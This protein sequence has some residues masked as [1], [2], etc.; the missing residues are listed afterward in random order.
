MWLKA[1]FRLIELAPD[2]P[3]VAAELRSGVVPKPIVE[4]G[5]TAAGG[6]GS[7]I[8]VA[9]TAGGGGGGEGEQPAASGSKV[10]APPLDTEFG[11]VEVAN[12]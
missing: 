10:T 2:H 11:E 7:G 9:A 4:T 12:S 5:A 6:A 1:M 3:D 8:P